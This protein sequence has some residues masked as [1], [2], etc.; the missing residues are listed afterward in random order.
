MTS[1]LAG[2]LFRKLVE[3]HII[4]IIW[5]GRDSLVPGSIMPPHEVEVLFRGR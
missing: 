2:W 3:K 1:K 5:L 4:G